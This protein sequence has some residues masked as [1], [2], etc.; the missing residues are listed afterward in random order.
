MSF[1]VAMMMD[2]M[3]QKADEN[4]FIVF[5]RVAFNSTGNWGWII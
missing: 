3:K 2:E 1:N 4:V 5:L